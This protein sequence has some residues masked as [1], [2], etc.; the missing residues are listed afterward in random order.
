MPLD[1]ET[2]EKIRKYKQ[3]QGVTSLD[4]IAGV[5]AYLQPMVIYR[6]DRSEWHRIF[7]KYKDEELFWEFTWKMNGLYP[8]SKLLDSSMMSLYVSGLYTPVGF[9]DV[10]VRYKQHD[11]LQIMLRKFTDEEKKLLE[12]IAR[13]IH[14]SVE[15]E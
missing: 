14:R 8:Y 9:R 13:D 11:Y 5:L 15:K 4:V 10:M 7:Y 6:Q 3:N 12:E 2:K 1:N